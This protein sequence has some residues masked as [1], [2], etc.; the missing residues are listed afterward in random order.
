MSEVGSYPNAT[1][2]LSGTER[3]LGDQNGMTVN[4]TPNQI[5]PLGSQSLGL[6]S[7]FSG[8]TAT[9]PLVLNYQFGSSV[10]DAPGVTPIRNLTDLAANFNAFE[11][12]TNLTSINSEIERYQSFNSANHIFNPTNL[13]LQAVNPNNDWNCTNITQIAGTVNLA[14]GISSTIAAL[15]L[16]DTSTIVVGQVCS[17]QSQGNYWITAI[18]TN[19]SVTLAPLQ[20]SKNTTATVGLVFWM[21]VYGAQ[22]SLGYILGGATMTFTSIPSPVTQ[23]MMMAIYNAPIFGFTAQRDQDYRAQTIAGN[24]VTLNTP[25]D[26]DNLGIGQIVWFFP[27]V[28]SGQIW[29]KYQIDFSNPQSF[30]ALEANLTLLSG[31]SQHFNTAVN[32][33]TQ[34]LAQFNAMP[35]TAAWGGWPAFWM[36]S[37]DDGNSAN[38]T[39]SA[40]EIDILE[41]QI[42]ASQSCTDMNTG[43][44]GSGAAATI[45]SKSGGTWNYLSAFGIFQRTGGFDWVG[46]HKYQLIYSNGFTY[47]FIDDQLFS[48]KQFYWSAE[49]PAQFSVGIACGALNFAAG[50]NTLFPLTQ[51]NFTAINN[52]IN[53][54]KIWYQAAS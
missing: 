24:V 39:A 5:L 22:L 12:F 49:R 53:S 28:T 33:S 35:N 30:I 13:Q 44:A 4:I 31:P 1:G 6:K 20:G 54:V 29:S 10:A 34:T 17:I 42:S 8:A 26:L 37:A 15:G 14:G 18:V 45:F 47:R 23:G 11:D 36:Y 2:P 46:T 3:L 40:S 7:T 38:E 27:V 52:S 9:A 43:N 25:W 19:T 50:Q 16:A 51:A 32:G 41:V 48:V 21:P